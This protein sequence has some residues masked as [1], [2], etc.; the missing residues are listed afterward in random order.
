MK[1]SSFTRASAA[2][3]AIVSCLVLCA[4]QK[5]T[6]KFHPG[7]RVRV[8]VTQTEGVVALRTRFFQENLYHITVAGPQ[9]VLY[10]VGVNEQDAAMQAKYGEPDYMHPWHDEGPFYESDLERVP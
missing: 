2:S 7:E 3:L 9:R 8:R 6:A 10:P 4:C 1:I 5:S